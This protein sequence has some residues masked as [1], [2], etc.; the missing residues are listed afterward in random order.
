MENGHT[1]LDMNQY[2]DEIGIDFNTDYYDKS[3]MNLVGSEKVSNFFGN[4]LLNNYN[5]DLS[6]EKNISENWNSKYKNYELNVK[7]IRKK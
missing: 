4:Y 6:Q 7:S 5:L 3:H 2:F 1:F